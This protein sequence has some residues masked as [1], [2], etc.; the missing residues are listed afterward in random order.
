LNY[1]VDRLRA[2]C[3]PQGKKLRHE[4]YACYYV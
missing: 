4:E 1:L 3:K 2:V